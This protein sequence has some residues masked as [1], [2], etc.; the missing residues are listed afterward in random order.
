M[1]VDDEGEYHYTD[2]DELTAETWRDRACGHCGLRRTP[3]GHDGC[4][5][6]LPGVVN[7]C[8]GHGVAEEAYVQYEGGDLVRGHQALALIA[9]APD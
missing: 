7:A 5:G 9:D 1:Y 2:T 3:E 6:T 8:C 4:I